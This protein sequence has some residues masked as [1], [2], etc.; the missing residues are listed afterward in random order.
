MTLGAALTETKTL[1]FGLQNS[2]VKF[3]PDWTE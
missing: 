3:S 2:E 1:Y